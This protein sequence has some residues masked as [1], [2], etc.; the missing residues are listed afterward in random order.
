MLYFGFA[1]KR[2]GIDSPLHLTTLVREIKT[3]LEIGQYLAGNH[4]IAC[5]CLYG[6]DGFAHQKTIIEH[7]FP[8][9]R[10]SDVVQCFVLHSDTAGLQRFPVDIWR[11]V[12]AVQVFLGI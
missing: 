8:G 9:R 7:G 10:P 4:C 12:W 3:P 5:F 6:Y 2:A 11:S 1:A